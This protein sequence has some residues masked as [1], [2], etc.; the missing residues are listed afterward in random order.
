MNRILSVLNNYSY[1]FDRYLFTTGCIS[2]TLD[3]IQDKPT[4]KKYLYGCILFDPGCIFFIIDSHD[5]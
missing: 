4:R 1:M 2:F 3:S 5:F